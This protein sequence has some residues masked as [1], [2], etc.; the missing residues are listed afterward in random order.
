MSTRFVGAIPDTASAFAG[1]SGDDGVR[2]VRVG[3]TRPATEARPGESRARTAKASA[4]V[5]EGR[6]EMFRGRTQSVMARG[7]PETPDT[8][9]NG[10]P[11]V[12]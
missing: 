2:E 1:F 5:R 9:R 12:G 3:G 11:H 7:I 8:Q 10:T 6:S 4:S